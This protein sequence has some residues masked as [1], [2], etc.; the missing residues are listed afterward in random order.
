MAAADRKQDGDMSLPQHLPYNLMLTTWSQL[1]NPLLVVEISL[2]LALNDIDLINNTS[3]GQNTIPT[4]LGRMQLGWFIIDKDS[5]ADIWRVAPF[6]S[7]NLV[8][9]CD[10]DTT[11]SIW[12]F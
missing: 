9:E 6:N 10:Q 4:T 11:V 12:V 7:T 3:G 1:L 8:L 5:P 2:G